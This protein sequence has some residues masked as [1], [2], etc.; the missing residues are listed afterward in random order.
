M[1]TIKNLVYNE[2]V[3]LGTK[4][5]K[6]LPIGIAKPIS[7]IQRISNHIIQA[8]SVLMR[9]LIFELIMIQFS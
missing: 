2:K 1:A 8:A 9:T 5:H 6:D 7:G 3:Y 4:N